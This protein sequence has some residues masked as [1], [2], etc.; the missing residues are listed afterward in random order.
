MFYIYTLLLPAFILGISY[1]LT[2]PKP[3]KI[4]EYLN[5]SFKTLPSLFGYGFFLYFLEMENLGDTGWAFYSVMFFLV[6]TSVI[7]LFL[8]L[9]YWI[10]DKKSIR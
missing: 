1:F 8:K 7:I 3:K 10:K 9:F 5:L 6:P 2:N 4:R